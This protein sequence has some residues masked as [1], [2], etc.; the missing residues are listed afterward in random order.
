MKHRPDRRGRQRHLV[1][2]G[3]S[4]ETPRKPAKNGDDWF[5]IVAVT[6]P[7]RLVRNRSRREVARDERE[8]TPNT[9]RQGRRKRHEH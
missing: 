7:S 1:T 9:A 5:A 6:N 2:I 4:N 8:R 3:E